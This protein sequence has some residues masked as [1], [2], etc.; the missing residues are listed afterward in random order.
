MDGLECTK[1]IREWEA[2]GQ[3]AAH[4]PIIGVTANARAEQIH[5]LLVAGMVG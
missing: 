2:E 3:L 1:R 5:T 4:V